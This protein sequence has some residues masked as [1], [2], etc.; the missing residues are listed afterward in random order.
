MNRIT[1]YCWYLWASTERN[2]GVTRTGFYSVQ[3]FAKHYR[4]SEVWDAERKDPPRDSEIMIASEIALAVAA[5]RANYADQAAALTQYHGAYPEAPITLK[6]RLKGIEWKKR[7]FYSLKEK[8]EI[9][10]QAWIDRID[11]NA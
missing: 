7:T 6:E 1:P 11:V 5:M 10:V 8:A 4:T 9:Y 2:S 3:P